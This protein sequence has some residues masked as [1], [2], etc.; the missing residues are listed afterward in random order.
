MK[1]T[2]AIGLVFTLFTLLIVPLA[3]TH[4]AVSANDSAEVSFTVDT[5]PPANVTDLS[6]STATTNSLTLTW[7]A[8]GD[9]GNNGTAAE[10]DIRYATSN[11]DN[12]T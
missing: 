2:E 9:D 4:H 10:Y 1:K 5:T 3:C 12:E 7:T 8:P 11:I 6:V